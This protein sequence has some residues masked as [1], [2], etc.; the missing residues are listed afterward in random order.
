MKNLP[1]IVIL[2][3]ALL[4]VLRAEEPS[5]KYPPLSERKAAEEWTYTLKLQQPG[6]RSEVKTG[7]LTLDGEVIVG[8]EDGEIRDTPYGKL[9]WAEKGDLYKHGWQPVVA[10][11]AAEKSKAGQSIPADEMQTRLEYLERRVDDLMDRQAKEDAI[12]RAEAEGFKGKEI[13]A[14]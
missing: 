3:L 12:K 11:V 8:K 13:P 10:V 5:G 7:V 9:R 4:P 1:V 14:R 6:T 2:S